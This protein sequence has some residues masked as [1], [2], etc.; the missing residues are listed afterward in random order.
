MPC[1]IYHTACTICQVSYTIYTYIYNMYIIYTW[2]LGVGLRS[3]C[4]CRESG[5]SSAVSRRRACSSLRPL[6]GV[7]GWA[8]NPS[9]LRSWN[10]EMAIL[11]VASISTSMMDPLMAVVSYPKAPNGPKALYHIVF[12]PRIL[13]I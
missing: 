1:T 9:S 11:M 12:G 7:L 4:S 5:R 13:E 10:S 8:L 6:Q 2:S 3:R